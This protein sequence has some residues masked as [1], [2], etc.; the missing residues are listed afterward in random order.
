MILS[1]TKGTALWSIAIRK[2][3]DIFLLS[4]IIFHCIT[5]SVAILFFCNHLT[6]EHDTFLPPR[7]MYHIAC[8]LTNA[9]Y[10][11]YVS[12]IDYI[13]PLVLPWIIWTI[14]EN[15]TISVEFS[16][17]NDILNLVHEMDK[18]LA[19]SVEN[20]GK[21]NIIGVKKIF[22]DASLRE[23]NDDS[24]TISIDLIL[25]KV[26]TK[27][28]PFLTYRYLFIINDGLGIRNLL[29]YYHGRIPFL[30]LSNPIRRYHHSC[31]SYRVWKE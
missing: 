8:P 11:S 18:I 7:L 4:S 26:L 17:D 28:H 31:E 14:N 16:A 22:E 9:S 12:H 25:R 1:H 15:H 30:F 24:Q 3:G 5:A 13:F 10:I 23:G 2:R 29:Q 21:K 19:E 6:P 20:M 27:T